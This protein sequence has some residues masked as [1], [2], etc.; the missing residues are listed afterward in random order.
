MAEA[1]PPSPL[2]DLRLPEGAVLTR[3]TP[4]FTIETV[5]PG[6]LANHST[7][8]GVWGLIVV[9]QGRLHFSDAET[10]LTRVLAAGDSQA[11]APQAVH[12]VAL[13]PDACFHVAF[14]R[15]AEAG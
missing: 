3:R 1:R 15:L 14:H 9:T 4:D 6:L 7:K 8:A 2:A 13:E 10:G 11:V 12:A 5:P